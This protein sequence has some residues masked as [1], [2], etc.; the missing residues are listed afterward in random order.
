MRGNKNF[1]F[2]LLLLAAFFANGQTKII[3]VIDSLTKDPI[4]YATVLFSNNTGIITDDNGRF[5]LL[6]EQYLNND[7]IYVSF[8]GYKTLSRELSSLKDSLLILSP[9]PIKLNEIVLTNREYSAEE[10]VGK[11]REN[12]SQNYEIQIL[13]NLLFFGQKESNE[14]NR[15]KISKYK[16][17]IKELNRSFLDSM[18][19]SMDKKNEYAIEVLGNYSGSF[20]KEQQKINLIKARETYS[21]EKDLTVIALEEKFEEAI[22]NN[23]KSNSYFKVKSGIFGGE[24]ENE[25]IDNLK[26]DVDSTD[27]EAVKRELA[28]KNKKEMR[29]KLNFAKN[30]KGELR[31]ILNYLF[32][33]PKTKLNFITKSNRYNF[34]LNE[35]TYFAKDP[36][37]V[38]S[39][40]P[41]WGEDYKGTIYVSMHDFAVLRMDFENVKSVW[42]F[43]LFGVSIDAY[44]R[45]GRIILSK[46]NQ[47]KYSPKYFQFSSATK[48]AVD[49]PL[50]FIEKN[51][52]VRGRRK[53][54]EISM[55][56]DLE[57]TNL[58]QREVRIFDSKNL[59]L[60]EY[61][62]VK[63]ENT[64]LPKFHEKFTTDFWEE[65]KT[66]SKTLQE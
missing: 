15:I 14:L 62:A 37:Y 24:M 5:E 31:S 9:N 42:S 13:D 28:E 29:R 64:V 7:S 2:F 56:I 54:N 36:V 57:T 38:L 8:I 43:D 34:T 65:L 10:I 27:T 22:K 12:I 66:S 40:K 20:K 45:S 3:K 58:S 30:R 44:K 23:V 26:G 47:G 63:E 19:S 60:S 53:Q 55:R 51:K 11:I 59:S 41:R 17:S 39:F 61:D 50:K 18:L 16:S 25:Y 49:R 46:N 52:F 33:A 21:Q 32:Y 6:E 4:P 35:M 48:F 1:V